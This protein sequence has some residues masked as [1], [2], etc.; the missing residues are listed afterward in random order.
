VTGAE[1]VA[2]VIGMCV[3]GASAVVIV[4]FVTGF[5]LYVAAGVVGMGVGLA[6]V[7]RLR[8]S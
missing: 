3:G 2:L 4:M 5:V 8:S 7:E 1:R 6:V